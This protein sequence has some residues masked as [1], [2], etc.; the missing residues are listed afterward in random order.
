MKTGDVLQGKRG[1]DDILPSFNRDIE[2]LIEM[3]L[4]K[5]SKVCGN[6][7]YELEGSE[8]EVGI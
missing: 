5:N 3:T 2:P 6:V 7:V 8:V 1:C 4:S